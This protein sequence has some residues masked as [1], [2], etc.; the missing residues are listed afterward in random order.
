MATRQA[1][2]I[3][4]HSGMPFSSVNFEKNRVQELD[5]F[6]ILALFLL[7]AVLSLPMA[8]FQEENPMVTLLYAGATDIL[9][10]FP[11]A[12]KGIE[13]IVYGSTK[14]YPHHSDVSGLFNSTDIAVVHT[15]SVR[16]QMKPS[17]TVKGIAMVFGAAAV[18]AL[19]ITLEIRTCRWFI[20][21]PRSKTIWRSYAT[22]T[23]KGQD[24]ALLV[25]Q[26]LYLEPRDEDGVSRGN[27]KVSGI[28]NFV[29]P[30]V[31]RSYCSDID[32]LV[33]D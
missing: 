6:A 12:I 30:N 19:G 21:K 1:I 11:M 13:L 24:K 5:S 8:M 4:G 16:C 17:I 18:M 3:R 9:R 32:N 25:T 14:Q 15:I 20:S 7:P 28:D 26:R 23:E 33:S 22:L 27:P 2:Q 31:S 29:F 10:A